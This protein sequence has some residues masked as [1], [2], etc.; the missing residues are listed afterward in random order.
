MKV[1]DMAQGLDPL[2][3]L[4]QAV[5]T[6]PFN[7]IIILAVVGYVIY[8][9]W[10]SKAGGE[11]EFKV[12]DFRETVYSFHEKLMNS[13]GIASESY[14]VRGIE[15][16]GKI[17]KWYPLTQEMK[18]MKIDEKNKKLIE[19]K[20]AS[21]TVKALSD[22]KD[23]KKTT[24]EKNKIDAIIFQIG[25]KSMFSFLTGNKPKF[26]ILDRKLLSYDPDAKKWGMDETVSLIPYASVYVASKKAEQWINNISFMRSQE[27]V[28]TY[29][30]NFARKTSWL[31]LSHVKLMDY[32]LGKED[33]K[34]AG[35][36]G[37]RRK[38][39]GYEEDEDE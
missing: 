27:E 35:W 36:E 29:S 12:E 13:F 17:A 11:E 20:P 22:E 33:K 7:M 25:T 6:F 28:L 39:L 18:P 23:K 3:L 32:V 8:M 4:V 30:Q 34:R 1:F 21:K 15:N 31:E 26:V 10:S 16:Q 24:D 5:T 2:E 38:A 19:V 14:L 37:F 9:V